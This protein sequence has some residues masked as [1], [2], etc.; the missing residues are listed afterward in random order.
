LPV[1]SNDG[2]IDTSGS[3]SSVSSSDSCKSFSFY[4]HLKAVA[5]RSSGNGLVFYASKNP[6]DAVLVMSQILGSAGGGFS[7]IGSMLAAQASV[8]HQDTALAISLLNLWTQ[9]GGAVGAAIGASIW[10]KRLPEALNARLG[11]IHNATYINEIYGSIVVA[12]A[13]EPR[14]QVIGGKSSPC[15]IP[16][17]SSGT[18]RW[19]YLAYLDAGHYI[20]LAALILTAVPVVA[21]FFTSNFYLDTRHNTIEDKEIVMRS[22]EEVDENVIREKVAQAEEAAR[23]DLGI[24]PEQYLHQRR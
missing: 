18:V 5:N 4:A 1:S 15:H 3:N 14:D 16:Y 24:A 20:F 12:R 10:T 21:G 23:R 13:A 22:A 9:A 19:R 6:T 2:L 11:S 17:P 8:P 7:V